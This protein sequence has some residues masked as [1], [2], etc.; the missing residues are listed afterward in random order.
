M[1]DLLE[2]FAQFKGEWES[3]W[4]ENL[5]E[6]ASRY[7]IQVA[8]KTL[9]ST[10]GGFVTRHRATG[11]WKMRIVVHD[12]LDEPSRYGVL[13]HELAHVLLGHL[14]SDT[15]RWWP[16]RS[17]LDHTTVE[18]EA[19]SVAY[20][21]TTRFG[22][23]GMSAGYIAMLRHDGAVPL[24]VSMDTVAKVAGLAYDE[25]EG[26]RAKAASASPASAGPERDVSTP[27]D[28]LLAALRIA[29]AHDPRG[30]VAPGA[31]LWCDAP[32]DFRP[33]LPALRHAL[34]N[35]LTLEPLAKL[36]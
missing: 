10:H 31:V 21:V 16:A 4:L 23:S 28:A 9:S 5:V 11:A 7:Q 35:L 20:I 1:L 3:D 2:E 25:D 22:F 15:D 32:G 34:P 24:S 17:S 14:G 36:R 13:C 33:L 6:N 26:F 27:L 19:E 12:G 29:A 18:I 30:E 8:F